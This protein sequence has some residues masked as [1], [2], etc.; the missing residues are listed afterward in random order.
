MSPSPSSGLHRRIRLEDRA[1]ST[2]SLETFFVTAKST[3]LLL[4]VRNYTFFRG[5]KCEI[6]PPPPPPLWQQQRQQKPSSPNR[7]WRFPPFSSGVMFAHWRERK[8]VGRLGERGGGR[9]IILN[10]W[11][12]GGGLNGVICRGIYSSDCHGDSPPLLTDWLPT[13]SSFFSLRGEE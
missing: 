10:G 6:A 13:S 12:W 4:E 2:C 9:D 1:S 11:G 7:P 8:S 3:P 5:S